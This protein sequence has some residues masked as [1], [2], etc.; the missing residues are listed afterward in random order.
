[1]KLHHMPS[2][3]QKALPV[4]EKIKKAGFEAYFVGG[5][6]RDA[7]LG[8]PIHDVDIASS[9]YPEETK[10]LFSRT[11]DIGIEHGTVLV[12]EN[13]GEYEVTTFRTEDSYV[14]YRRPSAVHF[15]RSLEEDLKRRDFTVNALAL[16]E[17]GEVIDLFTGLA[18]LKSHCLRAVGTA[19]E[20]FSEDALRVM[21]GFRFAAVLDFRIEAETLS[22]MKAH[23]PLLEQISVER[24]FVEFDKLLT[25]DFWK[26]GLRFL[27]DSGA[28]NYLPGLKNQ[29]L[30]LE[31]MLSGLADGFA[32]AASE[33]AWACLF[34][35]L[36][37][38]KPKSFLKKW[39][40]SVQL[41]KETTR[42]LEIYHL[43]QKRE[44]VSQDVYDYGKQALR[45]IE[46]LRQAQGLAADFNKIEELDSRLVIRCKQDI[47]VT[48]SDLITELGLKPG[49]QLGQLLKDIE[50]QIV[51]GVLPNDRAE[52]FAFI[53]RKEPS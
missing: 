17:T 14:D 39:K 37:L 26:K 29:G 42:L 52:I 32:F 16:T 53:K 18:D 3:F 5:S 11:V 6:V 41:Q 49:P 50:E 34:I 40:T 31:K 4:L 30:A 44:L 12:L 35:Y 23:A 47:S 45:Q 22:A 1:M 48:G 27:L 25:A 10:T 38:V 51:A 13:G 33:Q 43:R 24:C 7:V 2:E 46:E 9:S 8:R 19:S 36:G 21:R 28:E 15:V 20:R